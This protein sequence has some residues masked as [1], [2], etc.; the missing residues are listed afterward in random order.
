MLVVTNLT[1]RL[2]PLIRYPTGDRAAWREPA[3]SPTRKFVLQGRSSLGHR[4]RVGYASIFP[5]EIDA[6]ITVQLGKTQWQLLLEHNDS[7]DVVTLRIACSGREHH[8]EG[9]IQGLVA[10]DHALAEMIA[11]R[12]LQLHIQWC[13]QI[14]LICNP[15]TG[16]LQ[17]VVDRRTYQTAG[18][19]S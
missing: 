2:M 10:G 7:C 19:T 15:R 1:R 8:A 11:A 14:E 6:L 16:K 13:Q 4:L 12:Q 3:G 5:D 18:G 9:V 17:R